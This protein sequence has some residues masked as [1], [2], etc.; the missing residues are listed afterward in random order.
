MQ[1]IQCLPFLW[2]MVATVA[3]WQLFFNFY[4]LIYIYTIFFFFFPARA[5]EESL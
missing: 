4:V 2:Q 3:T 5:C 1:L